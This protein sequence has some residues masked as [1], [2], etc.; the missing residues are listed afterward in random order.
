MKRKTN[1]QEASLRE[2]SELIAIE[3]NTA[4]LVKVDTSDRCSISQNKQISLIERL[5]KKEANQCAKQ[6]GIDE[7]ELQAWIEQQIDTYKGLSSKSILQLLRTAKEYQ[8]DPMQEEVLLAQYEERWQIIISIDGWIK[9]INRHPAFTGISFHQSSE[10]KEGLP[11]WMECTITR[12]DRTMPIT[13]R[14]YLAEVRNDSDYWKK[15]P[16]RMLRHK[17]MQQCARIAL[18]ISVSEG[19]LEPLESPSSKKSCE[20][21]NEGSLD[22]KQSLQQTQTEKLKSML[23]KN[24]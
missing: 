24:S 16:R 1:S 11:I 8:L 14:E 3:S 17:A 5:I 21:S 6:I 18:A 22:S 13:T 15:M 7:D 23:V 19:P 10:E 4:A 9:L 2:N 12:S 20:T